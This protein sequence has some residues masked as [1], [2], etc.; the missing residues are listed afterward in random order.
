MLLYQ[1]VNPAMKGRKL[2]QDFSQ[3]LSENL[4]ETRRLCRGVDSGHFG[5]HCTIE[6]GRERNMSLGKVMSMHMEKSCCPTGSFKGC[7]AVHPVNMTCNNCMENRFP[8]DS[9]A[10]AQLTVINGL[11]VICI[12]IYMYTHNLNYMTYNST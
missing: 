12:Y 4:C 9:T 2:L 10:M 3:A 7:V 1:R 8:S 11:I 5:R 6:H